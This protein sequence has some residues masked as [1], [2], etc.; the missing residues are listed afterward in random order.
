MWWQSSPT[1]VARR[2][3]PSAHAGAR[4]RRSSPT[5]LRFERVATANLGRHVLS[6]WLDQLFEHMRLEATCSWQACTMVSYAAARPTRDGLADHRGYLAHI[7]A[8][9]RARYLGRLRPRASS[10]PT[11]STWC[12]RPLDPADGWSPPTSSG[13]TSRHA[14][15][16]LPRARKA[17]GSAAA[18]ELEPKIWHHQR[19][20]ERGGAHVPLARILGLPHPAR[21]A[22]Y[23][24]ANSLVD[25]SLHSR[26]GAETTNGDGFGVGWYGAHATP[27]VFRSIEPAWNDRNLR[28]L[29]GA[30]PLAAVLRAHPGRDRQPPCSRPTATRSATAAGCSCTT[31]TSTSSRR[32]SATWCWPSTRRCS[33][34][35]GH[36]RHRGAVLPRAHL[37]PG[38]RPAGAV[39]RAIGLVEAVGQ[40]PRRR[41][42]V[43]GDHRHHRRRDARWAFRYSSE[44]KSRSLFHTHRRARRCASST[45]TTELLR[46]VSDD[47]R[48]VVSEP[49]GDLAGAW[50]E[51]P[52]ASYG[53]V[54]P[55][56]AEMP[57][58]APEDPSSLVPVVA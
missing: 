30:H 20:H 7:E 6:P 38:G 29:A 32:S 1:L 42:P 9:A 28:E 54:G 57:I 14:P 49:L 34:H 58:V 19:H 48:L 27:G 22:L 37:R 17:S 52:E 10:A 21:E 15:P 56:H 25:Q 16:L 31:A 47:A 51:V 43:P 33:R 46:E 13:S 3:W 2:R 23:T 35:R 8:L 44:G 45:R 26:L 41:V 40:S 50:N 5:A 53:I 18:S 36:D 55:D 11:S 4:T 24:P 12:M 39:E